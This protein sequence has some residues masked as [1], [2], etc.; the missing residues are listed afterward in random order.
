MWNEIFQDYFCPPTHFMLGKSDL[1]F[2]W[3]PYKGTL[4][5]FSV[6]N[7]VQK[8][9]K[10]WC[11][12]HLNNFR[13]AVESSKCIGLFDLINYILNHM[14]WM[15]KSIRWWYCSL[16]LHICLNKRTEV[17]HDILFH[18]GIYLSATITSLFAFHSGSARCMLIRFAYAVKDS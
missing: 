14:A 3:I 4:W 12:T 11:V 5:T 16:N 6:L 7:S 1:L 17:I 18:P 15:N 2:F 9:K 10:Q 13:K 8:N